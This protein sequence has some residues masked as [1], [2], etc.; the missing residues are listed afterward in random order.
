MELKGTPEEIVALAA[1]IQAQH[2][3]EVRPS[4]KPRNDMIMREVC[5]MMG[6]FGLPK[7]NGIRD[8]SHNGDRIG[9]E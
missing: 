8:D 1:A 3:I 7:R 9:N 6:E 2:E 5:N 4:I